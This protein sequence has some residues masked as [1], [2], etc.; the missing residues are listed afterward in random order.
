MRVLKL[1]AGLAV[2]VA[3]LVHLGTG[4]VV[5]G[6][7]A[8]SPVALAAALVLGLV[9]T[10]ASA[11]RWCLVARRLGLQIDVADAIGDCYRAQFLNSVLPAGVLGDVHRAVDHG[12]RSGDVG[13]GVRAVV[14]ER[15]AGQVV[16]VAVALGVLLVAPG[17]VR[18]L[19]GG[20]GPAALAAGGLVLALLALT[21]VPRVR[22]ALL[23]LV[24]EGREALFARRTAPAVTAL[25][26]VAVA[27]HLALLVVA[28]RAVGVTADLEQL[29]P[30]LVLS[31][32]STGLP[33]NVG[34]WGPREATTAVAFGAA[35]LGADPGLATSVAFGVLALVSTAPGL[36]VLLLRRT[37]QRRTPAPTNLARLG[38]RPRPAPVA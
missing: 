2:V 12:S 22:R 25:S 13:R 30:L 28:A 32:L 5:D 6:L 4:A 34:G 8:I 31:L 29:L 26:L 3:V 9:S 21:A 14:L 20:L 18:V 36:V 23:D 10:A 35:G 19:L 27:G 16:L 11:A 7:R 33:V 24:R 1:L 15:V 38:F 37:V 17:P